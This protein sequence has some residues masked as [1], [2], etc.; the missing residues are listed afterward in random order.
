LKRSLK[1]LLEGKFPMMISVEIK[2][3]M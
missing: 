3:A 1:V 2:V